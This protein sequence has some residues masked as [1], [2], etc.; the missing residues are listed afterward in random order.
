V[1]SADEVT[2]RSSYDQLA[3]AYAEA[4]PDLSAET[5]AD[6]ELIDELARLV[7]GAGPVLDVGCGTGRVAAH[8]RRRGL[9]CL[10]L[11]LSD[12]MLVEARRRHPELPLLVGSLT[13]LPITRRRDRR[14]S[15]AF[16]HAAGTASANTLGATAPRA[17]VR[18]CPASSRPAR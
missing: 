10:G 4:F 2:A 8:L 12:G 5:S 18:P 17:T 6:R 3:P 13:R 1:L 11:D 14:S 7:S 9:T 16:A 15:S